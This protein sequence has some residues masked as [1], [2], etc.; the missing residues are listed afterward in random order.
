MTLSTRSVTRWWMTAWDKILRS[1]WILP[2]LYLMGLNRCML[3]GYI[4][5]SE[6]FAK[7]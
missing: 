2:V 1:S 7:M 5:N 4:R 6:L 3:R